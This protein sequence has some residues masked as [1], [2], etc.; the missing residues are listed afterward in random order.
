[1][2]V[3]TRLYK[4][5]ELNTYHGWILLHVKYNSKLI[6]FINEI[7]EKHCPFRTLSMKETQLRIVLGKKEL[8]LLI[9]AC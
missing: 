3:A 1:M 9:E 5:Y 4:T 6:F 2:F 7:I 8:H